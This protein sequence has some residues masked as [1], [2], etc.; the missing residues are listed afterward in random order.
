MYYIIREV[1]MRVVAVCT[2]PGRDPMPVISLRSYINT[3]EGWALYARCSAAGDMRPYRAARAEWE[4]RHR[5]EPAEGREITA[6]ELRRWTPADGDGLPVVEGRSGDWG[7]NTT[8]GGAIGAD[9]STENTTA[10]R[11]TYTAP[12][13][14]GR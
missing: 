13:N 1:D 3:P 2:S 6:E 14:S 10:P 9:D 4:R 12:S 5:D 11:C 7:M 8:T